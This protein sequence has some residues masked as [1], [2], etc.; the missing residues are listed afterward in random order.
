M[1][2]NKKLTSKKLQE[3]IW[4]E[5]RRIISK[6]EIK[7]DGTWECYTCGAKNLSGSNKHIGHMIPKKYLPYTMKYDLRFLKIQCYNC[8]INLGGMGAL[9]IEK[10]R[11]IEGDEYVD[12]IL[13]KLKKE[14]SPK[15][16]YSFYSELYERLL[17]IKK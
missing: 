2:K 10:M 15:K 13:S 17:L 8:N 11:K 4:I 16:L 6:R 1:A 14:I 5:V 7:E 3:K 12:D 9:F